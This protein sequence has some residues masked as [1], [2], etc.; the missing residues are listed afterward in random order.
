M[1]SKQN[2]WPFDLRNLSTFMKTAGAKLV[3]AIKLAIYLF[4]TIIA[5]L[6]KRLCS[7]K[8]SMKHSIIF[9]KFTAEN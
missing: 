3:L 7:L 2:F 9:E 1:I 8:G 6:N 4:V 5:I